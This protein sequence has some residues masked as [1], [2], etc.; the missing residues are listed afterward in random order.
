MLFAAAAGALSF[1]LLTGVTRAGAPEPAAS[2]YLYVGAIFIFLLIA[3]ARIGTRVRAAW[4]GPASLVA[5]GALVAN[6]GVLRGNER[7]WSGYDTSVRASLTAVEIAAPVESPAFLPNRLYAPQLTAGPYL[8]AVHDLG[9]PAYSIAGLERAAG[10]IRTGADETLEH[11]EELAVVPFAGGVTGRCQQVGG[12][13][14]G[15]I[16][17]LTVPAGSAVSVSASRAGV[18]LYLRRF[19]GEFGPVP[20]AAIHADKSSLLRLPAD[21]AVTLPWHL[22]VAAGAPVQVCVR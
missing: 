1:W 5:L 6:L 20:F 14:T 12:Q 9:S 19:G 17:D 13:A 8:A 15:A 2:R 7:L 21:R 22:G 3:E 18:S 10:S 16:A 11:A 4:M